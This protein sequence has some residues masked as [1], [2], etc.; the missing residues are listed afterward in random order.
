MATIQEELYAFLTEW[1]NSSP[2]I[3][4]QTSGSTGTPKRMQ[5]RKDQ[6]INSARMTCDFLGLKKGDKALL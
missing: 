4:V 6:M 5:V 3:E 1:N 2:T